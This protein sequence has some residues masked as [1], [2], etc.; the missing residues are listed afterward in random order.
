M[1]GSPFFI[2]LFCGM[3]I[4]LKR[5]YTNFVYIYV[6]VIC[7][8][9]TP[10][11]ILLCNFL[12]PKLI[13]NRNDASFILSKFKQYL[14]SSEFV[15]V[16]LS[17]ISAVNFPFQADLLI[18]FCLEMGFSSVVLVGHDDGGL[19]ALKAAQKVQLSENSMK[20]SWLLACEPYQTCIKF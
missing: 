5:C 3:D 19:L 10:Q 12:V 1:Q 11:D 18:S 4:I 16:N 13:L 7:T 8:C 6:C 14:A 2:I 17:I 15:V 20:V 9:M